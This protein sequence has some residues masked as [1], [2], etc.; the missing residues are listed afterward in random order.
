MQQL[1]I[2]CFLLKNPLQC[3]FP[4]KRL[5]AFKPTYCAKSGHLKTVRNTSGDKAVPTAYDPVLVS[6]PMVRRTFLRVGLQIQGGKVPHSLSNAFLLRSQDRCAKSYRKIRLEG[7]LHRQT[8]YDGEVTCLSWCSD[9][10][11]E[12]RTKWRSPILV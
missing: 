4:W 2:N 7:L 1:N 12:P 8:K 11:V 10:V 3:T 5:G 6:A 9:S